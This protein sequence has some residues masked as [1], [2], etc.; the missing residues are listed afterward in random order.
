[1]AGGSAGVLEALLR[2]PTPAAVPS[3]AGR[4]GPSGPPGTS[5]A[6]AARA[7][8]ALAVADAVRRRSR[9]AAALGPALR[10]STEVRVAWAALALAEAEP[11]AVRAIGGGR[12]AGALVAT[13]AG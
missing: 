3:A 11:G 5:E 2:S 1:A 4:P 6:T 9:I 12:G 7:A 10:V 13:V 8:G